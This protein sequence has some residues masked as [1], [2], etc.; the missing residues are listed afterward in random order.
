MQ[1]GKDMLGIPAAFWPDFEVVG[2]IHENPE[3]L[4]A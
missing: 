4:E 2:N 3:L 1:S